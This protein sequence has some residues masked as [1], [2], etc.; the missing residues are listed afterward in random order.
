VSVV[1]PCYNYGH[2]LPDCLASVLS[3]PDVEVDVLVVDDASPDGS[4]EVAEELAESDARVRVHRHARNA[5]HI[6]TYNDGL[7][8]VD[9]DYVVLLSA[10][11]VLAPGALGRATALLERHRDVGFVYGAVQTFTDEPPAELQSRVRSWVV[12]P[13]PAWVD[14]RCRTG[15]NPIT[16]PEVVMR[17]SVQRQIG[18]YRPELPHTGDL[19][20]WLRAALVADV[21]LL[22]NVVQACYRVHGSNM[23][24]TTFGLA[25]PSGLL[26]DLQE[27][28]TTYERLADESAAVDVAQARRGLATEATKLVAR[29]DFATAYPDVARGLMDFAE[30]TAPEVVGSLWWQAAAARWT[31][32]GG[33]RRGVLDAAATALAARD[34]VRRLSWDRLGG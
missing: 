28:R 9:G 18:F 4:G 20:M 13:G 30:A 12:W 29:T 34:R 15:R 24:D 33:V 5:G 32:K 3:Q 2:F 21:G 1:V 7:A 22:G 14:R 11:D 26:T 27:R 8:R 16:S 6:A 19:D 25:A 23:H 10:D 17:A 31:P